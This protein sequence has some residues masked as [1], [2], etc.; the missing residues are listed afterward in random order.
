M[1]GR[2]VLRGAR[3]VTLMALASLPAKPKVNRC[4]RL[5][6]TVAALVSVFSHVPIAAADPLQTGRMIVAPN[7]VGLGQPI[8][9][10]SVD[11]CPPVSGGK[12]MVQV[13]YL[14]PPVGDQVY[15]PSAPV[16]FP[17][18]GDG[19]WSVMVTP[20]ALAG[21][22]TMRADCVADASS[23]PYFAYYDV[24]TLLVTGGRG[25]SLAT[26]DGQVMSVG[27]L[28]YSSMCRD[29]FPAVAAPIVGEAIQP[30][31]GD[32]GWIAGADG[33]V[34]TLGYARFYGSAASSGLA[35]PV[36]GI[37]PTPSGN[38]YWLVARD[39]GIFT[40]GDARFFGSTAR[41]RLNQPI[42]GITATPTGNGYWLVGQD[43]G[44]FSFGD[45]KFLGSTGGLSLNQPVVGMAAS[46]SGNG[47]WLAS[48]D[49]G[50][51]SFGDAT[52]YGSAATL[53][54]AKPVAGI[55]ATATGAGYWLVGQDGGVF[56]FGDAPYFASS[57]RPGCGYLPLPPTTSPRFVSIAGS[58]NP[59]LIR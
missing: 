46:P 44:I 16:L 11:S 43:G 22:V 57:G 47:Y 14:V 13:S 1:T 28:N 18:A 8:T 27:D 17:T 33:G 31:T 37:A 12:P 35:A 4:V 2:T 41:T 29:P 20:S 9:V 45:A 15:A 48:E 30:S 50:V 40:F 55:S 51:F 32:G 54:L 52:F 39:G 38:G 42:V 34:I 49:G 19:S 7:K 58:P 3:H 5:T 59:A 10:S 36:V 24:R 26:A 25:Y 56:A 23:S 53:H 21:E 6:L